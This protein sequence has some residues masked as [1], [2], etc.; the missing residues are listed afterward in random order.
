MFIN[1]TTPFVFAFLLLGSASCHLT[2]HGRTP[3]VMP[4]TWQGLP[5]E[6]DGNSK[7]WPSPYPNYDSKARVAYATSND[8][9]YL[10]ITME[11]GDEMT[12]M[13][14]LQNGMTVSVDTSGKKEP[15]M[16]VNFPMKND[17]ELF[18]IPKPSKYARPGSENE[19]I[20][21]QSVQKIKKGTGSASQYGLEGF[22]PCSGGYMANQSSTCGVKVRLGMDEYNELVWEAAIPLATLFPGKPLAQIT[23][24]PLSVCFAIKGY[25]K[26]ETKTEPDN[27]GQSSA[28][29]GGSAGMRNTA[30]RG[31][32][33]KSAPVNPLQPLYE[34]TKTWKHFALAAKP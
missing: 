9:Q 25:K 20:S 15:Q 18:E 31:S 4:G 21:K 24:K 11:T 1:R 29:R 27:M 16:L 26:P 5:V 30:A 3:E 34:N 23:G 28:P 19:L 13:K 7:D 14:I 12:Q 33:P 8:E 10:Y 6:I 32:N 22:G 17:N 2:R